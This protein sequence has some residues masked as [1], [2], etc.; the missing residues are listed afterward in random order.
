LVASKNKS[1]KKP[2][3]NEK[4][5]APMKINLI[6]TKKLALLSAAFCAVMLAFSQNASAVPTDLTFSD[7]HELGFI[8][9]ST[10]G[11]PSDAN[12]TT[13]LNVLIGLGSGGHQSV[14]I[15]QNLYFV[16]R[17]HNFGPLPGPAVVG[18]SGTNTNIPIGS[19]IYSYLYATYM[20]P[21][22]GVSSSE[23]WYIG[24]LS[25]DVTIPATQGPNN[26]VGWT[27]FGPGGAVPDGGTTVMLLGAAL[28][29][30]GMARRF[31]KA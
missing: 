17:T 9:N 30:L 20:N 27:L 8:F 26:L 4:T 11:V 21:V 2:N 13:L 5:H 7:G 14:L 12:K 29:A 24:N 15:G 10:N 22:D 28:G 19:G 18:P 16:T 1:K 6:P 31:L 25:G 23:V 3:D